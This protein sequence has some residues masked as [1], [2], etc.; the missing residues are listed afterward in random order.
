LLRNSSFSPFQILFLPPA[1]GPS[2]AVFLSYS[3]IFIGREQGGGGTIR[4]TWT[5][6][7]PPP[8]IS[9]HPQACTRPRTSPPRQSPRF[10][11][12]RG[13]SS[14]HSTPGGCQIGYMDNYTGCHRLDRVLTHNNNVKIGSGRVV[15]PGGCQIGYMGLHG[16]YWLDNWL[17]SIERC[18]GDC[19]ITRVKTKVASSLTRAGSKRRLHHHL[20]HQLARHLPRG[21]ARCKLTH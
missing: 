5:C 6:L 20:R 19:K 15:T 10:C 21:V 8:G 7:R 9:P 14:L 13:G 12:P 16:P 18:F 2:R 1:R 3:E 17:S 11:S 4:T